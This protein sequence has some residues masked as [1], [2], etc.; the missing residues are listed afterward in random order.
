M[1]DFQIYSPTS[2]IIQLES[3]VEWNMHLLNTND[4]GESTN[5]TVCFGLKDNNN[6]I[7]GNLGNDSFA[8]SCD[9][10]TCG[11]A[12]LPTPSND[13][14]TGRGIGVSIS[15]SSIQRQVTFSYDGTTLFKINQA[16]TSDGVTYTYNVYIKNIGYNAIYPSITSNDT[17]TN[18]PS[19]W[20]SVKIS[21]SSQLFCKMTC[22]YSSNY[23]DDDLCSIIYMS[24][25]TIVGE[26]KQIKYYD[27]ELWE[28][29][30]Q[31]KIFYFSGV[32]CKLQGTYN[33]PFGKNNNDQYITL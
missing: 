28:Y 8:I 15:K 12:L 13:L 24:S 6:V 2:N 30:T 22:K 27:D 29:G 19:S 31:I 10:S 20:S 23:S 11:A 26:N 4:F 14:T 32:N 33:L 21:S 17:L 3:D 18:S 9:T 7:T 1:A 5:K 25:L 16:A